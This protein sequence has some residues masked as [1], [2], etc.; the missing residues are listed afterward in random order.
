M[1]AFE[2]NAARLVGGDV[3]DLEAALRCGRGVCSVGG[4][5]R[6][7]A[8]AGFGFALGFNRRLDRHHAAQLTMGAGL[9]RHGDGGHAG[10]FFQPVGERVDQFERALH[11]LLRLQWVNVGKARQTA[12]SFSLRRGLC[13][14]VQEPSGNGPA[15]IA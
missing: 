9:G 4:F 6:Q 11:R 7:D 13:F 8:G 12:P 15:S 1:K 3:V 5:R 14:M 10:H 2:I